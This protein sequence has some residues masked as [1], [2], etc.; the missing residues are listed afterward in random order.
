[1]TYRPFSVLVFATTLVMGFSFI[2]RSAAQNGTPATKPACIGCSVD[3]KTTPR[4][5]DGH[6]DL[7]GFW[8][9]GAGGD[10][11]I[12]SRSADGSVL[13]D[14]GGASRPDNAP[15]DEFGELLPNVPEGG[16]GR[17]DRLSE[18]P[19]KPEYA[20]KVKEM[21]DKYQYGASL[22]EDPQYDCKPLGI[23]RGAFGTMQIVQTPQ[24]IA[25]ILEA[26]Q[27]MVHR[28]IYMGGRPHP[29]DPDPPTTYMGD[30]TGHWDGDTLVIDTAQLSDE[31][32]LGGGM[33]GPRYA[34]MHSDQ[35]HAIERW[36]R[37]GDTLNWE[38]TIEDPVV[39]A[40]PWVVTPKRVQHS[41][42]GPD[43]YVAE[44]PCIT[45]DKGHFV[46][47]TADD[48]YIC[49]YCVKASR[50]AGTG[51]AEPLDK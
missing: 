4:T 6:P 23:P 32:W 5:P 40:Q 28:L 30:S 14:F 11:Y 39:F 45:N 44:Y 42:G 15:T 10:T 37:N 21:V 22:A 18:P 48:K 50:P 51:L 29:K 26:G 47:P 9:G 46:R 13:F 38:G 3:G 7:S 24:V 33:G 19:Y 36:T 25:V 34:L 49:N 41:R 12:S 43:D 1:M 16:T 35:E 17:A 31:T 2:S 27:N 8:S 20:A